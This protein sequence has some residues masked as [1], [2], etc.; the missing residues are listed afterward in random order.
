MSELRSCPK[1]WFVTLTFRPASRKRFCDKAGQLL[2]SKVRAQR[3]M[4]SVAEFLKRIRH[5]GG[6]VRFFCV[7]E[8]HKDGYPHIHMLLHAYEG[9]TKADI[10]S[11]KWAH[12]FVK[13]KL[14]DEHSA[15]YLVK[16]LTKEQARVRASIRYGSPPSGGGN[17]VLPEGADLPL[18]DQNVSSGG[19][20]K[21]DLGREDPGKGVRGTAGSPLGS[22]GP[23]QGE[24]PSP[25]ALV[26]A[27]MYNRE[28][29]LSSGTDVL[30]TL[31]ELATVEDTYGSGP[32]GP[33]EPKEVSGSA[34][35]SNR[36]P[37]AVV[38]EKHAA[39]AS[40]KRGAGTSKGN[41]R[42]PRGK[43]DRDLDRSSKSA[44]R[45]R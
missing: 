19:N 6:A 24:M 23:S 33:T 26:R 4:E 22:S 20:A 30:S 17:S 15:S 21:V 29:D 14:C 40:V 38:V 25:E 12:G 31:L 42:R 3:A 5:H 39:R 41:A 36:G 7:T 35:P 18:T 32:V 34:G 27:M 2:P 8:E 45:T 1:N 44:S 16:Y 13:A 9:C 11:A 43:A 28:I 37:D 10:E